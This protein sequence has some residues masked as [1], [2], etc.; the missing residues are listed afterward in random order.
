VPA[1]GSTVDDASKMPLKMASE[2]W[3]QNIFFS[4]MDRTNI[5]DRGNKTKPKK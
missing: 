5:E 4:G 1:G 3:Q 2:K